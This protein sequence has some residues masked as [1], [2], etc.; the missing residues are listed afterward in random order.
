MYSSFCL[1]SYCQSFIQSGATR[2]P[3]YHHQILT[4]ITL[5]SIALANL[6]NFNQ[7]CITDHMENILQDRSS[8]IFKN[9]AE[10]LKDKVHYI[11]ALS[12]EYG[13]IPCTF[14]RQSH[15]QVIPTCTISPI[16]F[17]LGQP[18]SK[19]IPLDN[20]LLDN[21]PWTISTQTIPNSKNSL[22][23]G[24]PSLITPV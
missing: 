9:P 8:G 12:V 21:L 16:L 4:N 2:L 5:E 19:Q 22:L 24:F 10:R 13:A 3:F 7:W 11:D 20:Y 6:V 23:Q 14:V 15:S 1:M 18:L 17:L